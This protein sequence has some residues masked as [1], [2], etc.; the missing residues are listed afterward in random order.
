[1]FVRVTDNEKLISGF[2]VKNTLVDLMLVVLLVTIA[3]HV[4]NNE[5]QRL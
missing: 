5:C 3:G 4:K 2:E 1:V